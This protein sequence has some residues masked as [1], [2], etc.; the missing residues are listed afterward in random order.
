[1]TD[2]RTIA[3]RPEFAQKPRPLTAGSSDMVRDA[4]RGMARHNYGCVVVVDDAGRVEGV[5]T[6]R[7]ILKRLIDSDL[8]VETTQ[9]GQIM[10]ANP[11]VAQ[12]DDQVVDWLRIMSNERFRRLPV[13]DEAGQLEAVFTQGDFVSYTWPEL[14]DGRM[15]GGT[16]GHAMEWRPIAITGAVVALYTMVMALIFTAR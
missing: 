8:D 12:R 4:V 1:M 9:V 6:E 11:R 5:M 14:T 2:R 10:T 7:D 16:A 13:V 15:G 3:Q